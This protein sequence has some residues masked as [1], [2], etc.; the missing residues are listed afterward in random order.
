M[1]ATDTNILVYAHR[2][3]SQWHDRAKSRIEDLAHGRISWG[4]PWPCIHEF[5]ALATHPR[6][7]DPASALSQ[8][9]DQ[10]GAWL[11]SP[12][13]VLL[14]ETGEHWQVLTGLLQEGRV[15]GSLVHDARVAAIC[16]AH[17]VTELWTADRD[18]SRFPGL[19]VRNP[20]QG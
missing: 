6:I 5:V 17:G 20:L 1:I 13:A 2:A 12:A 18:F 11:E 7:Y 8:A 3:D 9:I 16:I 14:G 19:A 15:T 10:V 4:L